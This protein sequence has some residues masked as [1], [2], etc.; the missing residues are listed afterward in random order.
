MKV[1]FIRAPELREPEA[2]IRA[3]ELTEELRE[4]VRSLR[5]DEPLRLYDGDEVR[6]T[7]PKEVIR[8]FTD[9]KGV[10]A[11]TEMGVFTVRERIYEL[12]EKLD[13]RSFARISNSEIVN[14]RKITAIDLG[15]TGTIK[16]TLTGGKTAF[17]S[18]RYIK[19]IK[20]AL[21]L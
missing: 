20:E 13:R 19:K 8:F 12:E 5:G 17:T 1:E 15:L 4:L 14:L 9:G 7:E 10:A 6:L 18:R 3:P 21:S 16:L 11:E 2:T